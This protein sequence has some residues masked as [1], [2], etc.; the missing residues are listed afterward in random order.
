MDRR[1]PSVLDDPHAHN[2]VEGKDGGIAATFVRRPVLAIVFSLLVVIA[3]IAALLGI[4]V[5]ELPNVDRPVISVRT[6]YR[7]AT[8]DTID[9]EVTSVIEGAVAR[10]PG[11]VTIS[12]SSSA[13]QSNVTIEFDQST[14]INVAASDLRD[15]I[16]N[17]RS[18]PTDA[19]FSPPTIVKAD[20]NA[21]AIMRLAVTSATM[22]IQDLT[23]LV[24][25]RVIDRLAAVPGVAD[26][27]TFGDRDPLVQIFIRPNALA[28]RNL[29]VADLNSALSTVTLDAPAGSIS[30]ANRTL[31]VRA[32]ASAKSADEIGAVQIN[33]QTRVADV[34]DVVFGPADRTTSLRI[35]G[36]NGLGLGIVRQAKANTLDISAGVN[37]AVAEL[38]A[39]LPAGVEIEVT[40]DDATFISGA[41]HEV[42]ITLAIATAIVIG[43][44]YLFLRSARVTFIPAITVPIAL[45]G[46]L[47]A[48]WAVGFSIN[49]LTL[50]ALVL[51][52]GLVVDDAIVVI[53]NISRQRGLGLGPRAAAVIGTRQ[54][55]FAVIATT[56]TL[57]AVFIP[58]SFFP[59]VAGSLFREFGFVLAFSVTLS[60]FIALTLSPMLAS[61]LVGE[62][63]PPRTGLGRAVVRFGEAAIRLYARLLD[64]ALAAPAIIVVAALLFAGAAAIGFRLLPS[65][66]TPAEDR[67]AVQIVVSAPQGST[68]DYTDAQMR[69][70]ERIAQPFLQ[71]GE[72]VSL[73][74]TGRGSGGFM[75]LTLAPWGERSRSQAEIAADLNRRL[76]AIP[77]VQVVAR[78]S[79]SLG[80]RGGGQGL[81]FAV[82]G[83]DYA[84][85]ADASDKLIRAM[86]QSPVF[87]RVQLNYDTTQPQV[88]INVDRQR[89]TDLGIPVDS[90]ASTVQTIVDSKDLGSFY[91]GDTAIDIVAKVPDGMI[92][93]VGALDNIDLR[94]RDGKMVPLSTL[95]TFTESAVAP[96]LPRQDQRRAIPI[97]ATL[98]A[99]VDLR[100]AMDTAQSL[101]AETLPAGVSIAFTGD[102]KELNAASNGVARTFAFA[103]IVVLLVLAA[104]FESFLSAFILM[105]TVPFGVAAAIFAI[106]FTGGSINIYSQ[107]GLV[108][109]VGLM[110]KNGILIVEFANQLRDA[111]QSVAQ[112]IRN[113]ALIRLRPVVM[114]MIATVLGALPLL[115][116]GG[117]GAEARHALG[118]IIVGGLGFA[119]VATLFLTPVVFDLLARFSKPRIAE[120]QRLERELREAGAAPG[121]FRPTAGEIGE[122]PDLP[123]AAE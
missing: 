58:I 4:E 59:G 120:E 45:V 34:A 10:T 116:R 5:R 74:S 37:Q 100:K 38:K 112:A 6:A 20:T 18:L 2:P 94:T 90:I 108:M 110:S 101:A 81:Q 79:N 88:S 35:N 51:A 98:A 61:R 44:I 57:A 115:L 84:T 36:K 30:D 23:K 50:L 77:G 122:L 33:P 43:I 55:F 69:I 89:A 106:L 29:T 80:I 15:A 73:F 8:P 71:S 87:D 40:G 121:T 31:L 119:T 13:G 11:V 1:V 32:D 14:D 41:I 117:A 75:F 85:L 22:S 7:G 102:A 24:Q 21:D 16:G 78:G 97:G 25:D 72:A 83:N 95:V 70:V 54:V 67:G 96:S 65:E 62:H 64:W 9:K 17:L 48:M 68:V 66:L 82:I 49:I 12:S 39:S 3:G 52:T 92:Q 56:A 105:A 123:A 76:Q 99:G 118:W 113:A 103:L 28:A 19:N 53:E 63:K 60:A 47:A 27:Q 86:E 91:I 107:I 114:T 109:L 46:T 42:L 111:G 93:D 104:Q 26:V